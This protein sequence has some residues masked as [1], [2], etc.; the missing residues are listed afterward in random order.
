MGR[1]K[2][3]YQQIKDGIPPERMTIVIPKS[4]RIVLKKE[5]K[6]KGVSVNAIIC[7]LLQRKYKFAEKKRPWGRPEK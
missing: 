2:E 7:Q 5:A 6:A 3:I 1:I 4:W